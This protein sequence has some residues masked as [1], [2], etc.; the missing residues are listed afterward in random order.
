MGDLLTEITKFWPILIGIGS[1]VWA[2]SR[3]FHRVAT[4]EDKVKT[5]FEIH[6]KRKNDG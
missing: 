3:L 5:L 2:F 4:I 1:A 6:N